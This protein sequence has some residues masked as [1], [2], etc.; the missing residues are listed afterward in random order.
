MISIGVYE[1]ALLS[2]HLIVVSYEPLT[3]TLFYAFNATLFTRP[4]C[5]ENLLIVFP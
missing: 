4:L 1:L 2:Q 5:P 3:I